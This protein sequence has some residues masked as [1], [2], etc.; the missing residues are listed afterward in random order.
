[1]D[2]TRVK[3]AIRQKQHCFNKYKNGNLEKFQRKYKE[4]K[5]HTQKICKNA[6]FNYVQ[7]LVTGDTNSKQLFSFIKRKINYSNLI[8]NMEII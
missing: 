8:S 3:R 1:M 4:I 2:P 7:N 6:H 5:K